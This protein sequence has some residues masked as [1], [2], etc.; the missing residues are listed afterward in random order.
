MPATDLPLADRA[1]ALLAELAGPAAVLR[2]DQLVAIEALVVERARVLVVQR[3]GWGKSAVYWIAT[4]LLR[5]QGAGPTLVVSPLL[6]LMRDQVAAAARMGITAR[7][8]NSTNV[9][10]WREIRG[11]A[12]G[13]HRRRPADLPRAAEQPLVQ[14]PGA[15][16]PQR[17][18]GHARDRRGP[19][20]LR[21]GP[22]LPA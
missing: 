8:I 16:P 9:D 19:L 2:P 15:P 7:T 18:C 4:R 10:A 13:R 17:G 3:T 21:L 11:R 22:R 1:A 6:A 20:H 12:R 14:D 5:D